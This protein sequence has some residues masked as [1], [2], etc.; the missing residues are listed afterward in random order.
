M[1]RAANR[2]LEGWGRFLNTDAQSIRPETVDQLEYVLKEGDRPLIAFGMGRSYGDSALPETG[3]AVLMDGLD[4]VLS[5]DRT[6]GLIKVE[7]GITLEEILD[8]AVPAGW[9]L[10]VTPGTRYPTL[11]GCVAADVHGKNH[12]VAGSI[13]RHVLSLDLMMA[14][15]SIKTCSRRNNADLFRATTGGMG[16][17][18]IIVRVELQLQAIETSYIDEKQIRTESLDE[19]MD[20]LV[21]HDQEWPYSVAWVDSTAH[22]EKLGRGA[23]ILGRHA[24]SEQLYSCQARQRLAR[25]DRPKLSIPVVPPISMVHPLTIRAFNDLYYWKSR[26]HRRI[27]PVY[28]YFYPLDIVEGWNKLYGPTG[29]VQYQ[30]VVPEDGAN[31]LIDHILAACRLYGHPSALT[32]LKRFGEG[33]DGFLSFPKPGWT[34]ALDLPVRPGLLDLLERF[35]RAVLDHGGRLYLAKDARMNGDM[36]ETM[37]PEL[38]RWREVRAKA[39]PHGRFLSQQAMRLSLI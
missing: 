2:H 17:T 14:D 3:A 39:D 28:S 33:D 19:T 36:L 30:F 13:S 21:Q 12:H 22:G 31:E 9:F 4:R 7:A 18:G 24:G 35:D 1:I 29:F 5:F 34:L 6:S 23:V 20:L 8:V 32:V 38:P 10:P 15:G 27:V 16:L 11:G 25:P 37:Y 26:T